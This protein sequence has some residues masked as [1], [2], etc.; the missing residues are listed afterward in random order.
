MALSVEE[1]RKE[2][3]ERRKNKVISLAVLHQNR[4][5]FHA[6]TE[7]STPMVL[8]YK[9]YQTGKGGMPSTGLWQPLSDFLAFVENLIPHDKFKLFLSLFRFPVATNDL[10]A[11]CFDKLSRIF[12]GRDP[13]FAY[14]FATTELRDDWEWY[15]QE[16]LNEPDVWSTKGWEYFKTEINSILVVDM[17]QEQS[18]GDRYPRPYFY[19]LPIDKV[20]S[21]DADKDGM[22]RWLAFVQD[23]DKLAVIDD[24]S[25][26][27][28]AYKDGVMGEMLVENR[29]D[30]G[31]CPARFFWNESVSL[32]Y[33]EVKASPVTKEL[34]AL[35]WWL[36]YHISKQHLDMYGSYP[37]YYGYEQSCDFH[38]DQTGDY[39]NGGFLFDAKGVQKLDMNGLPV[40]C[41]KCGEHRITGAGS[42][43]DV[44]VPV[45]G[46]PDLGSHPVGMLAVDRSSLD[47][48]V[49][50]VD[51]LKNNIITSIVGTNEEITTR[52]ALNE[53]Q[54]RAN[55]E[56]QSTV[57]NRV[58]KGF[59][60]AQTF[61]DETVC[62]LR[63]GN[64]FISAS[65]NYG[66][67]FYLTT[68]DDLRDRYKKAKEAGASEAELD[69]L[70][71]KIIE[72]E[73]RNNPL[74][75]Q[76]MIIL[77]ELEPYRHLTR[78]EMIELEAKG[79]VSR[80][81]LLVKLNFADYVRRF[82]RENMNI[83]DFGENVTFQRK[84]EA[85]ADRLKE[86][87]SEQVLTKQQTN[88]ESEI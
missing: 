35:D 2:I 78:N 41:P 14:Q 39:C 10:T 82:E 43:I 31:Y 1:I 4:I 45:E 18:A 69:A 72:T 58:K 81:D 88:N 73:Y 22:M 11:I 49:S 51:R 85:I 32:A 71:Q 26:R 52:D 13:A 44:P 74:M 7:A 40:P 77:A 20:I 36:F 6:Q 65:I 38:N 9:K 60:E 47:Y 67:E 59:E 54:I 70:Q 87:A 50:E 66:T 5:R 80:E 16:V 53:Q 57:L 84:I 83:L 75:Q 33:P 12:E 21:F 28:F 8:N 19:W 76:R 3:Q 48:N 25:Y 37:I 27:V 29:H 34:G 23:D 86:Y 68:V 63:Y 30:L 42:F 17:P 62:R 46:Q 15:R 56:S 64:L 79:L 61:V 55:F 24:E